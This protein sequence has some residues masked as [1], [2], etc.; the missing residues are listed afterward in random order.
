MIGVAPI[1]GLLARNVPSG[2]FGAC[3]VLTHCHVIPSSLVATADVLLLTISGR[4]ALPDDVE[5]TAAAAAA[6][7]ASVEVRPVA[8]HLF[9]VHWTSFPPPAN[10]V[11]LPTYATLFPPVVKRG[12]VVAEGVLLEWSDTMTYPIVP[13]KS[14]P[15]LKP[16]SSTGPTP[17]ALVTVIVFVNTVLLDTVVNLSVTLL[18][19]L[20]T[21]KLYTTLRL[22]SPMKL[23][24]TALM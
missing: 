7:V 13:M 15:L 6:V 11:S 23:S 18:P 19:T 8:T 22:T 5:V 3:D 2:R 20:V 21:F 14:S 9:P 16:Y 17:I 24:Y 12:W 1:L 10:N 4:G